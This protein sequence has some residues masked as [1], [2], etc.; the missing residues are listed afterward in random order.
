[1]STWDITERPDSRKFKLEDR[2][3]DNVLERVWILRWTPGNDET[4]AYPGDAAMVANIPIYARPQS[5]LDTDYIGVG[6]SIYNE[7]MKYFICRSLTVEP[8]TERPYTWLLRATYTNYGF[9]FTNPYGKTYLKQTRTVGTRRAAMYRQA[10]VYPSTGSLVWPTGV[11]DIGGVKV[12]TNGNPRTAMVG[13]QTIQVELLRDRTP[14]STD[15]SL[16]ADDPNWTQLLTDYINK[17][18]SVEFLGLTPGSVLC[19]GITA[20]LDSEM[21]RIQAS[22]LF[23]D[24]YHLEQVPI[25]NLT[26]QP[27]LLPGASLAGQQ[28]NQTTK[29]GFYQQYPDKADLNDL[30]ETPNKT[31]FTKAGPI[32]LA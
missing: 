31:Q 25:V 3:Q 6:T 12:D 22:F 16:T 26:G 30:F 21:W 10:P 8:M 15:T 32:R 5:R 19:T 1:M 18:N 20:T 4:A 7:W 28:I 13:Q 9:P 2:W 24:W 14:A 11:V 29:V 27:A 17:R 23:D